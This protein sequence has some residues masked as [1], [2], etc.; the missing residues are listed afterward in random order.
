MKLLLCFHAEF[1]VVP[2]CGDT[3][4]ISFVRFENHCP[5]RLG[6]NW[7]QEGP[8]RPVLPQILGTNQCVCS[9]LCAASALECWGTE[10]IPCA[11]EGVWEGLQGLTEVKL[12]TPTPSH[13]L[14]GK[15]NETKQRK[16]HL[17]QGY[18]VNF[19]LHRRAWAGRKQEKQVKKLVLLAGSVAWGWQEQSYLSLPQSLF[20]R[21][22][23]VLYWVCMARFW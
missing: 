8:P 11:G 14:K 15:G 22:V 6:G 5:T 23:R 17:K 10:W 18:Q 19:L 4:V 12:L 21:Q 7:N 20:L 9:F 16:G 1:G 3:L 2:L 13:S